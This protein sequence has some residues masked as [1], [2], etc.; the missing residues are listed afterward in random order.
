M[1]YQRENK[2][3]WLI[4]IVTGHQRQLTNF[5]HEFLIT[6]FD[7]SSDGQEIVFSRVKENSNI[8]MI[9]IPER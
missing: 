3:F 2:N 9:D 5:S 8:V 7:I 1:T 4:D 6:D